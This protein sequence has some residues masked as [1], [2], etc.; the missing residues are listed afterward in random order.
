MGYDGGNEVL[1]GS[2]IPGA[3][4]ND[5]GVIFMV[6]ENK[7]ILLKDGSFVDMRTP[8]TADAPLLIDDLK[9]VAGETPFLNRYADEVRMDPAQEEE[10]IRSC[11][12][13]RGLLL[14]CFS[15]GKVV[16]NAHLMRGRLRK[17]SHQGTI[18]IAIRK[19]WWGRGLGSALFEELIAFAMEQKL[20]FLNLGLLQI[21]TRARALYEK[22]GFRVVAEVPNQFRLDDGSLVSELLMQLDLLETV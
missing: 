2:C 3:S 16:G 12:E 17:N 14:S 10:W 13:D 18:G 8:E 19:D 20:E 22:Y 5:P 11:R 1:S 4:Q 15:D 9:T 21:N 6:H 7:R